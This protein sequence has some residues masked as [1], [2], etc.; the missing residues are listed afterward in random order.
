MKGMASAQEFFQPAP[1]GRYPSRIIA[2][3]ATFAKSGASML[4]LTNEILAP[5]QFAGQQSE[6]YIITDGSAPGGGMGKQK[7]RGLGIN[8]D[9]DAETPDALI[10]QHLLGR[11]VDVEYGN[12]TRM[13]RSIPNGPYD[14]E[15]TTLDSRTGL[16][17]AL[18]KLNVKGYFTHS[19]GGHVGVPAQA[20][21][22]APVQP[23]APVQLQQPQLS[24]ALQ[25]QLQ[26]QPQPQYLQPVPVQQ[27]APGQQNPA[28]FAQPQYLQP[29]PQLQVQPQY[30]PQGQLAPQG[31]QP[32]FL[33]QPQP[34]A[35]PGGEAIPPWALQGAGGP[36]GATAAG[37]AAVE[38][39]KRRKK[40]DLAAAGNPGGTGAE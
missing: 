30:A 11:Q 28:G 34:Q 35:Q 3:E 18:Q 14:K 31:G 37:Q 1:A 29:Q 23:I 17:V 40:V 7:L 21:Q 20:L 13:T 26:V 24:P 6:D 16:T 39:P 33:A 22:Q 25:P 27:F 19:L 12:E 38:A 5:P 15:M 36:N 2:A 8:V 4:K 10:A 32:S 9:T